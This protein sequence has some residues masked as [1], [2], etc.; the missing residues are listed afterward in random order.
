MNRISSITTLAILVIVSLVNAVMTALVAVGIV[1]PTLWCVALFVGFLV[2]FELLR[3][4]RSAKQWVHRA[5]R[6]D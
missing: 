5:S 4:I 3:L 2:A 1:Q 6:S